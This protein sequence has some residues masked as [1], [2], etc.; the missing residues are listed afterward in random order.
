[1]SIRKTF[2]TANPTLIQAATGA[3]LHTFDFPKKDSAQVID[4]IY[5]EESRLEKNLVSGKI[6]VG[7]IL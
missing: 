2:L 6:K 3:V 1:M 4:C 7:P 5:I